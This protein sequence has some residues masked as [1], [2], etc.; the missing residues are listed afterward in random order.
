MKPQEFLD[1]LVPAAQACQRASGIP[2]SFTL[3]QAALES[4]W[5]ARAP[6]CNLFGI[7]ADHSWTGPV[8]VFPTHEVIKGERIAIEDR[9]RCYRTWEEGLADRAQFFRKNPRYADCFKEK[10]GHGWARAVARA[11]YATDP[12]YADK[13]IAIMDGRNMGRFDTLPVLP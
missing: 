8:T 7:K 3:A 6:G 11:G 10:T 5:G 12:A 1:M 4:S 13:L 2:S 9:F